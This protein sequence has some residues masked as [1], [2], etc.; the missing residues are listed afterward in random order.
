[1]SNFPHDEPKIA[2]APANVAATGFG[3]A[4]LQGT[5]AILSG[6]L[7]SPDPE[8]RLRTVRLTQG[9]DFPGVRRGWGDASGP[10]RPLSPHHTPAAS[11]NLQYPFSSSSPCAA[12]SFC[13]AQRIAQPAFE[14]RARSA[15][16]R[17]VCDWKIAPPSPSNSPL[18][19]HSLKQFGTPLG[20]A[21]AVF[22]QGRTTLAEPVAPKLLLFLH[23]STGS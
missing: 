8:V 2:P 18:H 20:C 14:S 9:S 15:S 12:D 11:L 13:A 10:S 21:S 4:P 3:T 16:S 7:G 22:C 23:S 19:N 17:R 5:R 6:S 1:M